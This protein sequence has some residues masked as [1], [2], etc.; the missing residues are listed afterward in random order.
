MAKADVKAGRA[1]VELYIKQTAFVKGLNN[2]RKQLNSFG[3]SIMSAGRKIAAVGAVITGTL[4]AATARFISFGDQLDKASIRTGVAAS[5]L[6]QLGFAAEQSGTNLETVENALK[7]MAKIIV[8][9]E[10]GS[11]AASEALGR[12]GLKASELLKLKPDEQFAAIAKEIGKIENPTSRAAAAMAIFG[13]SGTMILPMI[14]DLE[15]LSKEAESLGIV[16]LDKDVKAAAALG[17]AFNRLKRTVLATLFEIGAAIEPL[18]RKVVDFATVFGAA[19]VRVVRENREAIVSAVKLAAKL[20][21]L[22]AG[23][24]AVGVA[25]KLAAAGIA[26]MMAILASPAAILAAVAAITLG[27]FAFRKFGDQ[28]KETFDVVAELARGGEIEAAWNVLIG[29]LKV[30]W[31]EFTGFVPRVWN[32]AVRSIAKGIAKIY[33]LFGYDSDGMIAIIDEDFDRQAKQILDE[34]NDAKAELEKVKKEA[35]ERVRSAKEPTPETDGGPPPATN[36]ETGRP[37]A[38]PS[39][40]AAAARSIGSF[41]SAAFM[42]ESGGVGRELK[43]QIDAIKK[44]ATQ[45]AENQRQAHEDMQQQNRIIQGAGAVFS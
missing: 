37:P 18:V 12:I 29:S 7:R 1:F 16:P 35:L 41:S 8:D 9:S 25:A 13:K 5:K 34:L 36:G 45:L 17:D 31:M 32:E 38:A 26:L 6:A 3:D 11:T 10:S 33:G 24:V 21:L 44:V 20:G 42:A 19:M 22:A 2:A 39:L 28:A 4:G 40:E 30:A 23:F 43:N 27:V 15:N 14:Q